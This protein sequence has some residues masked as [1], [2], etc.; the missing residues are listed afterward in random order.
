VIT[1]ANHGLLDGDVIT[2]SGVTGGNFSTSSGSISINATFKVANATANTFTLLTTTLPELQVNRVTPSGSLNL[3][4]AHFSV[5]PY[6]NSTPSD[7]NKRDRLRAI[8][9]FILTSPDYTIQR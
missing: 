3:T 4:N 7:T 1:F 6:N 8:L 2:I 9:H 5:I